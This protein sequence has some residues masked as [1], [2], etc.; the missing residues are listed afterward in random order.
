MSTK[1]L[2]QKDNQIQWKKGVLTICIKSLHIFAFLLKSGIEF[3]LMLFKSS[4]HFLERIERLSEID[5]EIN[6]IKDF[7]TQRACQLFG[8]NEDEIKISIKNSTK[9]SKKIRK[10]TKKCIKIITFPVF[11]F[12]FILT[13]AAIMIKKRLILLFNINSS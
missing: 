2:S 9:K 8:I 10:W 11:I 4:I 7:L 6:N 5:L 3:L 13:G 12:L 1:T